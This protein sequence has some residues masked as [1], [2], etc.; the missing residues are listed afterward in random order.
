M[1]RDGISYPEKVMLNILK[2]LNIEFVHNKTLSW[3]KGKKYDFYIPDLNC[4]VEMHG[5]QHYYC[6]D[7]F[8]SLNS[9]ACNPINDVFKKTLAVKNGIKFYYEIDCRHSDINYIKNSLL[10]TDLSSILNLNDVY[11]EDI[12]KD[13]KSDLFLK[14]CEMFSNNYK[15]D[16]IALCTDLTK[17]TVAKYIKR[18]YENGLCSKEYIVQD[19]RNYN[20]PHLIIEQY[21][22]DYNP[23]DIYLGYKQAS[24][25][26]GISTISIMRACSGDRNTAGGFIWKKIKKII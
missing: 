24:L 19:N 22:L 2:H 7:A 3:S 15:V 23:I 21:D 11:W 16:E 13:S 20:K 4:I 6:R 25:F 5:A 18:G 14:C 1:A 9:V 12:D 17:R 8:R 26:T 10:E